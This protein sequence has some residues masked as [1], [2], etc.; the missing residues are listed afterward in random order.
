LDR[1]GQIPEHQE[2][3]ATV[4]LGQDRVKIRKYIKPG[5]EGIAAVHVQVVFPGPKEGF[6]AGNPLDT[7]RVNPPGPHHGQR[8]LRKIIPNHRNQPNPLRKVA[9]RQGPVGPRP[10]NNLVNF[11][12]RGFDAVKSDGSDD[13][14]G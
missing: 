8:F 10:P 12:K 7:L 2:A 1:G 6:L 4:G 3:G 11:A 9:R 13:N 14:Q 5:F